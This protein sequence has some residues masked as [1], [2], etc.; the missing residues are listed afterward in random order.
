MV[1]Q[2]FLDA[3]RRDTLQLIAES[4]RN[5]QAGNVESRDAPLAPDR[6]I[7]FEAP[8]K[9]P[10][11]EV[12]TRVD[13]LQTCL[14]QEGDSLPFESFAQ[15]NPQ[16]VLGRFRVVR[17][18][19]RGGLGIVSVALDQ[20]LNREVALKQ[21]VTQRADDADCRGRF[22]LEAEIT[23]RLEHPGI[24]PVYALGEGP[25]GR[26]YYAMRFVQGDT[27]Q[28]AIEDFHRPDHPNRQLAGARQ[29]AL[30]Q[31]LGRFIDVCNALDY[32]HSR[33][34]LHRDVKPRNILVGKY[35]ETLIVDW[36]L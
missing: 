24:V 3:T 5:R 33:G 14:P 26:P 31:L 16:D 19:A 28:E 15:D 18:H 25:D 23:G 10:Q 22:L 35:G 17:S 13:S 34:V 8:G 27:L 32:A 11:P 12:L 20:D 7:Q 1:D 21:L 29:L 9:R 36:G 2:G 4:F 30:S 6:Q